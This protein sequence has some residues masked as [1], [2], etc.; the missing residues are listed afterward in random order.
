MSKKKKTHID[1]LEEKKT[2]MHVN[3]SNGNQ[4]LQDLDEKKWKKIYTEKT[5]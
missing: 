5:Y 1:C 3:V 4:L 2:L